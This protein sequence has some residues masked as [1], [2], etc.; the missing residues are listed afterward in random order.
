VNDNLRLTRIDPSFPALANRVN[1]A[2]RKAVHQK[3]LL[4]AEAR[5]CLQNARQALELLLR[6]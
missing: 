5:D 1:D 3:L 4:E 6:N 2:G